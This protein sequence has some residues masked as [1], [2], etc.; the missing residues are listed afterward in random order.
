MRQNDRYLSPGVRTS[1]ERQDRWPIR[2]GIGVSTE[3]IS[4]DA[5][6]PVPNPGYAGLPNMTDA[7]WAGLMSPSRSI[8]DERLRARES[9]AALRGRDNK[10]HAEM[11]FEFDR[12]GGKGDA[13]E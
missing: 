7:G 5:C 10:D 8:I 13:R 11:K 4:E 9:R 2:E 6:G 3:I 12:A 1:W